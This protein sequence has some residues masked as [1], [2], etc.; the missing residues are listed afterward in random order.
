MPFPQPWALILCGQ[1]SH[2]RCSPYSFSS[3]A[4]G[5]HS[6]RPF[7]SPA[8][9]SWML[10][11]GR[12]SISTPSLATLGSL[13][14]EVLL[15][16]SRC[17]GSYTVPGILLCKCHPNSPWIPTPCASPPCPGDSHLS[18]ALTPCSGPAIL[19]FP[20]RVPARSALPNHLCLNGLRAG[21]GRKRL[22]MQFGCLGLYSY[23]SLV[24]GLEFN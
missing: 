7:L 21:V 6:G 1:P 17:S 2:V 20:T 14:T 11:L 16:F 12:P 5:P 10:I 22:N 13:C 23:S 19:P 8:G 9:W 15:A 3:S 24:P 18:L 4:P